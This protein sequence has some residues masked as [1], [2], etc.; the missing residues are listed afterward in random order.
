MN[1]TSFHQPRFRC[2]VARTARAF[3]EGAD[4]RHVSG[5]ADCQAFYAATETLEQ[6]LRRDASAL[7]EAAPEPTSEL[8][9]SIMRAVREDSRELRPARFRMPVWTLSAIAAAAIVAVIAVQWPVTPSRS[10]VVIAD[11]TEVIVQALETLS[12]KL[13]DTVIP[14]TGEVLA[15]NPLQ[16]ELGSV[17][18]DAR[19][20][21]DF[22]VLNF[23]P[24]TPRPEP[25]TPTGTI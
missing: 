22:L 16:K 11:E 1:I 15:N 9:H 7:R 18:S 6:E 14:T 17:Y 4:E 12:V 23:M 10:T 2:R 3:R 13:T 24:T 21:L 5:C 25:A 8:A 19:S 20:A